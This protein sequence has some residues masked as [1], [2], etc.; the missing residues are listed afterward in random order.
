MNLIRFFIVS[1][2]CVIFLNNGY[3]VDSIQQKKVSVQKGKSE[4][5]MSGNYRTRGEVQNGYNVKTYGVSETETFLLSRLRLDLEYLYGNQWKFV[6]QFQDAR[7]S[8]SSFSD[9]DFTGKNNPFHDPFDI[10]NLFVLFSPSEKLEFTIG[11]QAVNMANRRVFGPGSW[12]NTGRYI[13]DAVNVK[14]AN[15]YFSTRLLAGYNIVHEPGIF[16]NRNRESTNAFAWYNTINKLPFQLD[17]FYV[18]KFDNS[19]KY[20]GETGKKGNLHSNYLGLQFQKDV[21]RLSVLFLGSYQFGKY[22]ADN[23]SA[24]GTV[25]QIGYS[26]PS[27]LNSKVMFSHIYGSGDSNPEDGRNQTF[28]GIYSGADTDLYSWMNFSFWKNTQQF[29]FDWEANFTKAIIF[30]TE[31]HAFFLDKEK[32]AWYFPGKAMRRD[33]EGLSGNFIGHELDFVIRAK[34][35]SWVQFLGGYCFFTPGEFVKNTGE[36]LTAQW[37]FGEL[38]FAF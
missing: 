21:N 32:D 38:T 23:I 20:S 7:V 10:N 26:F 9:A 34:L 24:F 8:G 11:R 1:A 14:F 30:R 35:T 31:Y 2:L 3:A 5:K 25:T 4:F 29:R 33:T 37:A 27:F 17:M 6:T 28:D 19:G 22:A 13:W 15:E 12:G 18:Y 16:P 36:S